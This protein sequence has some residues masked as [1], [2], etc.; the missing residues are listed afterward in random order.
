MSY[1]KFSGSLDFQCL[2]SYLSTK[3]ELINRDLLGLC[4]LAKSESIDLKT[5]KNI[6]IYE[7]LMRNKNLYAQ[8]LSA[9]SFLEE[10]IQD[11]SFRIY[12]LE[13][14]KDLK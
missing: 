8:I 14:N 2:T 12:A 5:K 1:E 11:L 13:E 4:S 9:F 7:E 6:D 10:E 3:I